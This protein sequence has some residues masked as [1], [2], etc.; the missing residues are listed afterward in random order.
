VQQRRLPP[1]RFLG[2]CKTVASEE[3]PTFD[4]QPKQEPEMRPS[5]P[6]RVPTPNEY[7]LPFYA[8]RWTNGRLVAF[9]H[10]EMSRAWRARRQRDF[11]K[12]LGRVITAQAKV[13]ALNESPDLSS[14]GMALVMLEGCGARKGWLDLTP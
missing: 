1:G 11:R 10:T 8:R 5:T 12:H 3:P 4:R 9:I 7:R 13:G 2:Q 6:S 14:L